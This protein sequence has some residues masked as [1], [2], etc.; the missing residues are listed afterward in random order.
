MRSGATPAEGALWN[1][2]RN[3]KLGGLRFRRQHAVGRFIADFY[4]VRAALIVEVDGSLHEPDRDAERD[5]YLEAMG[6]KVLRFTNDE[7][8]SKMSEVLSKISKAAVEHLDTGLP[9][10]S[11][12]EGVG[13]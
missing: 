10:S 11:Q 6:L 7:V 8:L 1:E 5:L 2:L 12:G 9:L 3:G 13:G 4:C